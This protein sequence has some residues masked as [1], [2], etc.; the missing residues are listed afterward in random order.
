MTNIKPNRGYVAI[1]PIFEADSY[2]TKTGLELIKPDQYKGR[3][4]QGIVKYIGEGVSK[5]K[6]G[7]YVFFSAYSGTLW[8]YADELLILLPEKRCEAKLNPS[9]ETE[10]PGLYFKEIAGV[11]RELVSEIERIIYPYTNSREAFITFRDNLLRAVV[12]N[13][14]YFPATYSHA[15]KFIASAFDAIPAK[16][17]NPDDP[18]NFLDLKHANIEDK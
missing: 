16:T 12:Q 18:S 7:D 3:C 14:S 8:H 4:T 1:D 13:S 17:I 10:I 5:V 2:T 6:R 15:V 11:T 9:G